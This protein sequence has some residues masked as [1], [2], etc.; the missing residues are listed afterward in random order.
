MSS[1]HMVQSLVNWSIPT[2]DVRE[3]A[4]APWVQDAV[5]QDAFIGGDFG[6]ADADDEVHIGAVG[7]EGADAGPSVV[8]YNG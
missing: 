3:G 5:A 7:K 6:G 1:I 4:E 8:I 2:F